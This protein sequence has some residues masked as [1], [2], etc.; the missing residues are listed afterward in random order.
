MSLMKPL[1]SSELALTG[2]AKS[3]QP[4]PVKNLLCATP[5]VRDGAETASTIRL[6]RHPRQR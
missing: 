2:T 1:M 3:G 5:I 4:I 6:E